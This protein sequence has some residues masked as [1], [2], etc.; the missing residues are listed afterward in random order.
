MQ[1]E[2]IICLN[3]VL[4]RM[5]GHPE[6]KYETVLKNEIH[7]AHIIATD[8]WQVNES[9]EAN[10][11]YSSHIGQNSCYLC[12]KAPYTLFFYQR[13]ARHEHFT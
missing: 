7:G 3:F 1:R 9:D 11:Q 6:I 8:R 4:F 5:I 12:A 10:S 13:E 2:S